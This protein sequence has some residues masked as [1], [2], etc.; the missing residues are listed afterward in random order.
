MKEG[1]A[2][3]EV[4]TGNSFLVCLVATKSEFAR[5]EG[6]HIFMDQNAALNI[7]GEGGSMVSKGE[8]VLTMTGVVVRL[9][10]KV[11]DEKVVAEIVR[12]WGWSIVISGEC[13]LYTMFLDT[14]RCDEFLI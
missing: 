9:K 1:G 11:G 12:K 2:E 14:W 3:V 5:E 4:G 10:V 7:G 6:T 13:V 8:V